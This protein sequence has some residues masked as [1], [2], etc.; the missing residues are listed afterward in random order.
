MRRLA[1]TT[2][3]PGLRSLLSCQLGIAARRPHPW[4]RTAKAQSARSVVAAVGANDLPGRCWRHEATGPARAGSRAHLSRNASATKKKLCHAIRGGSLRKAGP[5]L[6]PPGHAFSPPN[7]SVAWLSVPSTALLARSSPT[8]R[9]MA[10]CM[11]G[12]RRQTCFL[13]ASPRTRARERLGGAG[14]GPGS[15]TGSPRP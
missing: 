10:T 13:E 8:K 9:K 6:L 5:H 14:G 7:G 1:A 2:G 15:T 3:S 11:R 4:C 12:V